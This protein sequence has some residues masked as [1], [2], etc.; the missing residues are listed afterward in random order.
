MTAKCENYKL[1][2]RLMFDIKKESA[3]CTNR[4]SMILSNLILFTITF[5]L[6]GAA[7]DTILCDCNQSKVIMLIH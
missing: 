3:H 4:L 2:S 1:N 7:I 5:T 6:V